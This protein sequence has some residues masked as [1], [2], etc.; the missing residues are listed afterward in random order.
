MVKICLMFDFF[1]KALNSYTFKA[2]VASGQICMGL[3]TLRTLFFYQVFEKIRKTAKLQFF[4]VLL[5]AFCEVWRGIG[6]RASHNPI[7]MSWMSHLVSSNNR[8]LYEKNIFSLI[9]KY[10]CFIKFFGVECR[11]AQFLSDC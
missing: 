9:I 1:W 6:F 5:W 4:Q 11:L 2:R 10:W 7:F 8:Y 3:P